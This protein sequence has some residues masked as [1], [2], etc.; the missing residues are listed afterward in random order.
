MVSHIV[1]GV[2]VPFSVCITVHVS[3]ERVIVM[4]GK[5]TN[6]CEN[7]FIRHP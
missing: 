1:S 6:W 2:P 7:V 4:V 3:R 5:Q